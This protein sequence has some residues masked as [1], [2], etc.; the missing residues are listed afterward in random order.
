MKRIPDDQ[1]LFDMVVDFVCDTERQS[2]EMVRGSRR[3]PEL[4][5]VRK[6]VS[7]VMRDQFR[8]SQARIS[9]QWG[10]DHTTVYNHFKRLS[11]EESRTADDLGSLFMER[12]ML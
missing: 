12:E 11:D 7:V 10:Y 8:W 3:Y 2:C 9:G 6:I 5:R 4:V 1:T